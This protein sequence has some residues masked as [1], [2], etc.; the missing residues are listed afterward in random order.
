MM[1]VDKSIHRNELRN[2][3]DYGIKIGLERAEI[4]KIVTLAKDQPNTI[5]R[6]VQIANFPKNDKLMHMIVRVAFADGKIASE[7]LEFLRLIAKKMNYSN[8][9][10]KAI[11]EEEK[12]NFH[13]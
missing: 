12:R 2:I 7:E 6:S 9:E 10:L 5:L 11:L 8:D 4:E 3:L 1:I 13:P